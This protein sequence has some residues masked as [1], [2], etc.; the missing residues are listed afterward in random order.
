MLDRTLVSQSLQNRAT[1]HISDSTGHEACVKGVLKG[2]APIPS[3]DS[4]PGLAH[5]EGSVQDKSS[6]VSLVAAHTALLQH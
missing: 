1:K 2:E 4:W 3:L 6:C 5:A